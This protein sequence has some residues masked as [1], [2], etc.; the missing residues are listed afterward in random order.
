MLP[1]PRAER[2]KNEWQRALAFSL[3]FAG[4]VC[5]IK[6]LWPV[7]YLRGRGGA[8]KVQAPPVMPC[9]PSGE[10]GSESLGVLKTARRL[11]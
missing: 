11:L 5:L 4:A 7:M 9:A 8:F 3:P 1:R 2:E 10:P 6:C